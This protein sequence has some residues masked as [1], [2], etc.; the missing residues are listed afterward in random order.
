M[1]VPAFLTAAAAGGPAGERFLKLE[2]KV[3]IY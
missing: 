1:A 2:R 3:L